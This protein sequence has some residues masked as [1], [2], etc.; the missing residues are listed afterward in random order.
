M[1]SFEEAKSAKLRQ[2]EVE[3]LESP[4]FPYSEHRG[5]LIFEKNASLIGGDSVFKKIFDS[6]IKGWNYLDKKQRKEL[7]DLIEELVEKLKEYHDSYAGLKGAALRKKYFDDIEKYREA[8]LNADKREKIL[9]DSFVDFINIL[10]R[11]MKIMGLDNSWRKDDEIYGLTPEAA[12]NKPKLWM[13]K[14]FREK[15]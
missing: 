8:V 12:R 7:L 2:L 11:K 15:I 1:P 13:F 4:D 14:I 5:A 10:S 3:S 9:H 6:V